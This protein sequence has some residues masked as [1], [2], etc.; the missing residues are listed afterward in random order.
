MEFFNKQHIGLKKHF[1][2]TRYDSPRE[3][4]DY[5][6]DLIDRNIPLDAPISSQ[7]ELSTL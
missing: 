6:R 4:A 1:C 2:D 3:L 5:I 7:E